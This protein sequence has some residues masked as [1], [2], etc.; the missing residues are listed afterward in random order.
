MTSFFPS[1]PK[2]FFPYPLFFLFLALCLGGPLA[3]GQ[4]EKNPVHD[5]ILGK[6]RTYAE[7]NA[8]EKVYVQT[9]KDIYFYGETIWF[10]A[11]LVDGITHTQS[12]KSKVIY[13][14][15]LDAKDSVV[16]Q[17]RLLVKR[18]GASGDITINEKV[19]RGTYT[20]RAHTLYMLNENEP[21]FFRKTISISKPESG[22]NAM[23]NDRYPTRIP[24]KIEISSSNQPL[25]PQF[26][27]E[28]G[29][30]VEG[31]VNTM[32]FE[33]K[34]REGNFITTEGKIMEQDGNVVSYFQSSDFG[35][36]TVKFLPEIG[37]EYYATFEREGWE[38]RFP[39]PTPLKKGTLLHLQN[40]GD[41]LM[42][43]LSTTE[44]N[45]L[46]GALL[47]G[48]IRGRRILEQRFEGYNEHGSLRFKLMTKE[49]PSRIA[50]FI[51]FNANGEPVCERQVFVDPP[52]NNAVLAIN[53]SG[54]DFGYRS[55]VAIDL[56]V[57]NPDKTIPRAE[58]SIS[59]FNAKGLWEGLQNPSCAKS[60]LLLDS[61]LGGTIP[62]PDFFFEDS[63]AY[64]KQL[65]DALILTQSRHKSA[66]NVFLVGANNPKE[67]ITP[68][69]GIMI[70]GRTFSPENDALPLPAQVNLSVLGEEVYREK[71]D[72]DAQGNFS[73]GPFLF[74]DSI[75]AMLRAVP[76]NKETTQMATIRLDPVG[77]IITWEPGKATTGNSARPELGEKNTPMPYDPN[78]TRLEEVT[79]SEKKKTH[80]EFVDAQMDQI[81]IYGE[82]SDRVFM[83]SVPLIG[84]GS[85]LEAL[86]YVPGVQ[87]FGEYPDQEIRIR[88]VSSLKG[89][90]DPLFLLNSVPV[91]KQ[92]IQ[93]MMVDEVMFVD[94]LRGP[95]A[96][97]FGSRS[98]NGVI[99]FYSHMEFDDPAVKVPAPDTSN[100]VIPGFSKARTFNPPDHS[101]S[102]S[103]APDKR[104]TL[105]WNPNI[106]LNGRE[107][108]SVDF[109][110]GDTPG[111]YIIRVEGITEDGRPVS[112]MSRI[113]VGRDGS[114]M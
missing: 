36:G 80:Q 75:Y 99:A 103:E 16:A 46:D 5:R 15:L 38:E 17:R 76:R 105:Y 62:D 83:D 73:F 48:H 93:S 8:P 26:F 51:L 39:L 55:P 2:K 100:F 66:R 71:R 53:T 44:P 63:S 112:G 11:Y 47:L 67:R 10:K 12:P 113:T 82:P 27:P 74:Q 68:E 7:K 29:H 33:I 42:I 92:T 85:A 19:H 86:R 24:S 109:Y 21:P 69:K 97:I 87:V 40:Q 96:A 107:K 81:T 60:W 110:T 78:V 102:I 18:M 4:Y 84:A 3:Y 111:D 91:Q 61:D 25:S 43:T 57:S 65:L 22:G 13:V 9:D 50:Q 104:T 108:A 37:K 34:D 32:G 58:L 72:T 54:K 49:L 6:L 14:E 94:V 28:G 79:V 101:L 106:T 35:L 30:L 98:S 88:G 89:F 23:E 45:G 114:K 59:V 77:K 1:L 31:L 64:R 52:K 70:R 90:R 20:L 41:H 95:R 56:E